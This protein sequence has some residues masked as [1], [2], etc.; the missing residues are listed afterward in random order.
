MSLTMALPF[1]YAI[2]FCFY[3]YP[4][5]KIHDNQFKGYK[6]FIKIRNGEIHLQVQ[7]MVNLVAQALESGG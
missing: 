7:D 2:I 5:S 4:I 3:L 6:E 1:K